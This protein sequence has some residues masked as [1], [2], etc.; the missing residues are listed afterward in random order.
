MYPAWKTLARAGPFL[1]DR[2]LKVDLGKMSVL[3]GLQTQGGINPAADGDLGEFEILFSL[4]DTLYTAATPENNKIVGHS[5][6]LYR[7]LK[8]D[9]GSQ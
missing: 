8:F 4:D 1:Y 2:W 9:T 3:T 7:G 5:S 6:S